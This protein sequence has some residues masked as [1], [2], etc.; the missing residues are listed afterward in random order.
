MQMYL[1]STPSAIANP[2]I[3]T[4]NSPSV[5]QGSYFAAKSTLG[6]VIANVPITAQAVLVDDGTINGSR[7][8]NTI[9]NTSAING[10]IALVDRGDCTFVTKILNAQ[11]AG[12]IAVIVINNVAGTPISM[13]GSGG[14]SITIPSVMI[15]L[16]LGNSIKSQLQQGPVNITLYDS[17]GN[18]VFDSSLDNGVIAHE[19]THGVSIRLTGGPSV[20]TCLSNQEQGGEGWSDFFALAFTSRSTDQGITPRGIASYLSDASSSGNGIRVV[21]YSTSMAVNY[22][23]YNNI[24]SLSVPHG[25]GTMW[26]SCL[27]DLFW[28]LTDKYGYDEDWIN[29]N[30]GNNIALQLVMDGLKLQP[31]NPGFVDSRDAILLA[32]SL[33]FNG[34][35]KCLIWDVFARR[36][37]GYLA[38]QGLNTS[39]QDGIT[40]FDVPASCLVGI[41]EYQRGYELL[42]YPNPANQYVEVVLPGKGAQIE[43]YNILGE[44]LQPDG[45]AQSEEVV[46]FA[47]ENLPSGM[48]VIRVHHQGKSYQQMIFLNH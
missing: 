20:S 13:G 3:L 4:I 22:L 24:K 6:P 14:T 15:N 46:R 11:A 21:R 30:G 2:N 1:W 34:D 47:V 38:S 28:A 10:K 9:I 44:M 40:N 25:I 37:L 23:T 31:C 17:L 36:G 45:T 7:G 33:F 16:A 12:A 26:A 8:C 42:V 19:F 5:L 48:Y 35:H 39:V 29:G 41:P 32:D 27:W 43:W 18:L